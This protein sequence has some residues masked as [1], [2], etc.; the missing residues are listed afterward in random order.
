MDQLSPTYDLVR[1]AQP[2]Y[3]QAVLERVPA[4]DMLDVGFGPGQASLFFA[5]EGLRVEA[6]DLD[7]QAVTRLTEN[8]RRLGVNITAKLTD[9]RDFQPAKQ[10]D[11]ILAKNS[12]HF[13]TGQEM[14]DTILKLQNA[15]K[16][17]GL[18]CISVWLGA[19]ALYQLPRAVDHDYLR[20]RYQ[21]WDIIH[22][23]SASAV[24]DTVGEQLFHVVS[25]VKPLA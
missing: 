20:L 15:T 12:L 3:I 6:I 22:A 2:A 5:S 25:A 17:G 23:W 18:N 4:G 9:V 24:H 7:V 16:P 19:N 10:Y 11:L 14:D 8:A 1:S 13:L 21:G